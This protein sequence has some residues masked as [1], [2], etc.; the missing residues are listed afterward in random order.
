MDRHRRFVVEKD[1]ELL[2]DVDERELL[3][4]DSGEIELYFLVIAELNRNRLLVAGLVTL[5][6]RV[7]A[8]P[9]DREFRSEFC[10]GNSGRALL[11][12]TVWQRLGPSN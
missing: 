3:V 11:R 6:T 7:A 12:L 4:G 1:D 5:T 8:T 9:R 2:A 10:A